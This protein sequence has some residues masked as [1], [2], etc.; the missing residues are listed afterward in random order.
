MLTIKSISMNHCLSHASSAD[1]P[2]DPVKGKIA[3][4]IT[5]TT[6]GAAGSI[7]GLGL[8]VNDLVN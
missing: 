8:G 7:V 6:I 2:L 5:I 3:A 4:G 1:K